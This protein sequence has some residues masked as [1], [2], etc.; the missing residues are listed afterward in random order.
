MEGGITL[1]GYYT[2]FVHLGGD[3]VVNKRDIVGIFDI[4]L[5]IKSKTTKKFLKTCNDE[6][7]V[8]KITEEET[9]SFV[10]VNIKG[11]NN[12]IKKDSKCSSLIVYFSP[13]SSLT[14]Q[15]RAYSSY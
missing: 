1:K 6:G 13:I 7:F 10:I 14:L 11:K 4:K 5:S 3:V 2:N 12:E 15:K 9:R 8:S